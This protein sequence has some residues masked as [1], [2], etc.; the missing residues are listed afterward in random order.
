VAES[1]ERR[2]TDRQIAQRLFVTAKSVEVHLDRVYA[3][4]A[5]RGATGWP[6]R[7]RRLIATESLG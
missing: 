5:S 6:R 1:A 2:L 3:N 4:S 7:S